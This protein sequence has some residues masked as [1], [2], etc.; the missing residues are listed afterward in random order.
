MAVVR[1]L[2]PLPL[3]LPHHAP[4]LLLAW[5][6]GIAHVSGGDGELRGVFARFILC[7]ELSGCA[8]GV[9]RQGRVN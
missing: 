2:L 5:Q 9:D 3:H 6:R 8:R 1:V 7:R 4:A